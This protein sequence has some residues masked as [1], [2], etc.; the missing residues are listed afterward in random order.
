VPFSS[1]LVSANPAGLPI[2]N[3]ASTIDGTQGADLSG[4]SP[5][6]S[7]AQ[8]VANPTTGFDYVFMAPVDRLVRLRWHNGG[9]GVLSD[10]DGFGLITV[11]LLD[12]GLTPL[13]ASPWDLTAPIGNNASPR[14]LDFAAVNGVARVRFDGFHKQNPG[15]FGTGAP[16]LRQVEAFVQ[17]PVYPCLRRRSGALEWYNAAGNL[18]DPASLGPC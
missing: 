14:Q 8:L 16:L 12:A 4:F 5:P 1:V 13:F 7:E 15:V 6:V 9:G 17:G 11:T 3:L 10:Q 2:V 18:V